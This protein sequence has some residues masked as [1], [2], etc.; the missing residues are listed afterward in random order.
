VVVLRVDLVVLVVVGAVMLLQESVHLVLMSV[1]PRLAS[2]P[3]LHWSQCLV[4]W[5]LAAP[6]EARN[7]VL[8]SILPLMG[9]LP[10]PWKRA[11]A[12]GKAADSKAL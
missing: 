3:S 12:V 5:F 4:A 7:L 8:M 2:M 9:L 1:C 10:R 11:T 6:L